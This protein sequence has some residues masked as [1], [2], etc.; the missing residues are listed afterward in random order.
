MSKV[1]FEQHKLLRIVPA[2]DLR[3]AVFSS[4][5]GARHHY[6]RIKQLSEKPSMQILRKNEDADDATKRRARQEVNQFHW[7]MRALFWEVVAAFDITL[8]WA[9]K[10]YRLGIDE[11]EVHWDSICKKAKDSHK[12]CKE[13]EVLKQ[14]WE[15]EW[16]FEVRGYRNFAH[17]AFLFVTNEYNEENGTRRLTHIWLE[18]SRKG[19]G[20]CVE[21]MSQIWEY[22]DRMYKSLTDVLGVE[23]RVEASSLQA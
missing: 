21:A 18:P 3:A 12:W 19:Q 8:Q 20:E 23:K 2:M 15:S 10:K 16:Y 13:F 14:V 1:K 17:R 7:H 9:N 11:R 4:I 6:E 5:W 22:L